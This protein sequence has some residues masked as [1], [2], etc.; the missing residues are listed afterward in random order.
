V[1]SLPDGS[2]GSG[3]RARQIFLSGLRAGAVHGVDRKL[4]IRAADEIEI[5]ELETAST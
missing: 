5:G 1:G 4:E 2:L 3:C